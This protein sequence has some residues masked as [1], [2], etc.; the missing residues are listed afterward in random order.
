MKIISTLFTMLITCG[1]MSAQGPI[2]SAK[3]KGIPAFSRFPIC[4]SHD[5]LNEKHLQGVNEQLI[6]DVKNLVSHKSSNKSTL[7][8]I[9][10]VFHIVHNETSE[11]L[12]DSVIFNQLDILNQSFRRTN[13]DTINTRLDFLPHVG[14]TEIEFYFADIS[15]NKIDKEYMTNNDCIIVSCLP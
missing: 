13:S 11:N 2:H 8:R 5:L 1:F 7:Y 15:L 6:L 4:G 12:P 3:Y 10:V 9:P 14:D